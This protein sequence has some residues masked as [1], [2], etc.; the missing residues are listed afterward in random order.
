[1]SLRGG[2]RSWGPGVCPA[3][4]LANGLLGQLSTPTQPRRFLRPSRAGP[5]LD[6]GQT[7]HGGQYRPSSHNSP[8]TYVT[9]SKSVGGLRGLRGAGGQPELPKPPW[10]SDPRWGKGAGRR[11]HLTP[12]LQEPSARS[13]PRDPPA[14]PRATPQ[15]ARLPLPASPERRGRGQ[16]VGVTLQVREGSGS[17]ARTQKYLQTVHPPARDAGFGLHVRPR[18]TKARTLSTPRKGTRA[19]PPQSQEMAPLCT[20]SPKSGSSSIPQHLTQAHPFPTPRPHDPC[21]FHPVT[22]KSSTQEEPTF[23]GKHRFV[24][25]GLRDGQKDR[26][27]KTAVGAVG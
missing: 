5:G 14:L 20:S 22:P 12:L 9:R 25:D 7:R 1:M 23:V 3:L 16:G 21:S 8:P 18:T 17:G 24:K 10:G 27:N 11:W 19:S 4:T 13:Q 26:E 15:E 2:R 6:A